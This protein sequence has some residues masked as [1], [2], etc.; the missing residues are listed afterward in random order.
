MLHSQA[1]FVYDS[2]KSGAHTVSHLRSGR[3]PIRVP[4]LI[5]TAS[6]VACHEFNFLMR[7]D[8]PNDAG[9]RHLSVGHRRL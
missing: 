4:Y 5:Q 8:V 7:H 9:G 6:F 2:H 1:Y 3:E